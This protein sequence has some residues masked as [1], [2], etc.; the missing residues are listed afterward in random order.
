VTEEQPATRR[1]D[2]C[3]QCG[4]PDLAIERASLGSFWRRRSVHLDVLTCVECHRVMLY[5]AGP[6]PAPVR[7][8]PPRDDGAQL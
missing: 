1:R 5:H 2:A 8:Q 7:D 6:V 3:E 4:S